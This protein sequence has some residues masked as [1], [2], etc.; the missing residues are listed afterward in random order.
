MA[1]HLAGLFL[2]FLE[3]GVLVLLHDGVPL[4]VGHVFLGIQVVIGRGHLHH[5]GTQCES[6]VRILVREAL[7]TRDLVH[8]VVRTG[9]HRIVLHQD[10]LAL[11]RADEG[12][13]IVAV[14]VL[15][16]GPLAIALVGNFLAR[17]GVGVHGHEDV[18]LVAAVDVEI[19]ADRADAV[20]G[21][22]VA[23]M[24]LVVGHPPVALVHVPIGLQ[25]MAV[26]SLH[27]DDF[28]EHALLDHV[29]AGQLEEI[30]A[31]VFQH[32]AVLAGTLGRV[33]QGPAFRDGRRSGHLDGDMLPM[34]HR[35]DRDRGMK[36]PGNGQVNQVDVIPL[37]ELL[38]AFLTA[39]F[40]Q[41]AGGADPFQDLLGLFHAVRI[42]VAEGHDGRIFHIGQAT[43]GAGAAVAE[44][45]EAD[46]D[47]FD[48]LRGEAQHALL[49]RRARRRV[50][51]DLVILD[52]VAVFVLADLF[53][54]GGE[55]HGGK[56]RPNKKLLHGYGNYSNIRFR[57]SSISCWLTPATFSR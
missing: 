55:H 47:V 20:G 54:A 7:G 11:P 19:L 28:T 44:T 15:L 29:Q 57:K 50:V 51:N 25:V 8:A 9:R 48:R 26:R 32:H 45:D 16:H 37:A 52:G 3:D 56:G 23:V 13:R 10:G 41:G 5:V 38:V 43:D 35:I 1:A 53:G 22:H 24:V 14:G 27:M 34:L 6:F 30:V 18:H 36:L 31:A 49:V 17:E 42:Q 46:P 12:H 4:G 40:I 39:V 33:H 2:E 21:I